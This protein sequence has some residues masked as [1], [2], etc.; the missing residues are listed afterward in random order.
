MISSVLAEYSDM[1]RNTVPTLTLWKALTQAPRSE[2]DLTLRNL[3]REPCVGD[4][5]EN[6]SPLHDAVLYGEPENISDLIIKG[7]NVGKRTGLSKETPIHWAAKLGR[8]ECLKLLSNFGGSLTTKD[9]SEEGNSAMHLAVIHGQEE[10]TRWLIDNGVCVNTANNKGIT[11]LV[12]AT[13]YGYTKLVQTLVEKGANVN[14]QTSCLNNA[15]P[16]HLAVRR[17]KQDVVRTLLKFGAD[18][19]LFC[20]Y[21]QTPVHWAAAYGNLQSLK[22]MEI[23]GADLSIRMNDKCGY[24]PIHL[25]AGS[26]HVALVEWFLDNGIAVESPN[27]FGFTPLHVAAVNGQTETANFLLKRGAQVN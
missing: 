4:S 15:T 13:W 8:L 17:E 27:K 21:N 18:P 14:C 3:E 6:I 20:S 9:G 12:Y 22:I 19:K 26:G 2:F 5:R 7:N 25:A 10:I 23:C 16:L 1:E 11:P 24:Q